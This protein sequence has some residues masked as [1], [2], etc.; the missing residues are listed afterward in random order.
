MRVLGGSQS[1]EKTPLNRL[2]A[3]SPN[4]QCFSTYNCLASLK[5]D[6]IPLSLMNYQLRPLVFPSDKL[7]IPDLTDLEKVS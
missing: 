3:H 6:P 1:N 5:D 4:T 2:E 7:F